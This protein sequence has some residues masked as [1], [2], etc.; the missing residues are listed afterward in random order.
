MYPSQKNEQ[1]FSHRCRVSLMRILRGGRFFVR[2]GTAGVTVTWFA[3]LL[4]SLL[5]YRLFLRE[6]FPTTFPFSHVLFEDKVANFWCL[7]NVALKWRNIA[8]PGIL[9]K[10]STLLTA[11]GFAPAVAGL[12]RTG[13]SLRTEKDPAPSM[14]S[15]VS[16]KDVSTAL[17]QH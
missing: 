1:V 14:T 12:L 9:V 16:I 10:P 5:S 6:R 4:P 13:F 7:S 8:S 2:L 17:K 15:G 11:A 3:V